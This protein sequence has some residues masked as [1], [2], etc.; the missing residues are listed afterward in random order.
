MRKRAWTPG[1]TVEARGL[2]LSPLP[3]NRIHIPREEGMQSSAWVALLRLLPPSRQENLG[4]TMINGTEIAVHSILHVAD[5][6]LL[7]RGRLMGTT[8]GVGFLV[9]PF[10][11][12]NY[13][14]LQRTITE[15]EVRDLFGVGPA[16]VDTTSPSATDP[17][18]TPL[19]GELAPPGLRRMADHLAGGVDKASLLERLRAR[20]QGVEPVRRP[21]P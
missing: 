9:I 10:D 2:A 1:R 3:G 6:Y 5:D 18:P 7:I 14:G 16:A 12:I 13:L 11:R 4:L 20:R 15:P 21:G 19:P 17:L 8:E